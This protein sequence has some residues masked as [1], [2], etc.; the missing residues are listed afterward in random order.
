MSFEGYDIYLCENG[1]KHEYDVYDPQN[2]PKNKC[3]WCG[4]K[5]IFISCIDQ[6]NDSGDEQR[7]Q[8]DLKILKK[9][10]YHKC[11]KCGIKTMIQP[12]CY[13]LIKR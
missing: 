10:K 12:E 6:T 11:K 9:A 8:L 2:N 7:K 5:L 3:Q 1:H 13:K 4:A